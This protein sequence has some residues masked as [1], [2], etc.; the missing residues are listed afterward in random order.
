MNH[1]LLGS[2]LQVHALF[3]LS[4]LF[5]GEKLFTVIYTGHLFIQGFHSAVMVSGIK[6]FNG[7]WNK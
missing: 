7:T 1:F 6:M 3:R 5:T 4:Y 2:H